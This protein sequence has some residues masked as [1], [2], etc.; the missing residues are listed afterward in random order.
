MH[1]HPGMLGHGLHST[2]GLVGGS[3]A[4]STDWST[5]DPSLVPAATSGG[6]QPPQ[7]P[8]DPCIL[9]ASW[10]PALTRTYT[11]MKTY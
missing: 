1:L 9:L 11:R 2:S 6:S 7:A 8:G 10:A 5:Q 4:K 3:A